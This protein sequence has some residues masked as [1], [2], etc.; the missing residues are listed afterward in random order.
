MATSNGPNQGQLISAAT[1]DS[2][3]VAFRKLL[4]AFD[5]RVLLTVKSRTNVVPGS[6]A[7]G[8]RYLV[9][10]GASG[11]WG[12]QVNSVAAW[13]TDDPATPGGYWEFH[14]PGEGWFAWS[15]AD[16][17]FYVFT[18]GAWAAF[19]GGGGG[20]STLAGD[21]DVVIASPAN[22]D[23]LTFETSSGKWK[24]KPAS[25]GGGGSSTLAG[26]SDVVIASPANNDLLTFETSSGKWKNKPASGGGGGGGGVPAG[27]NIWIALPRS[28]SSR[29]GL[30]SYSEYG[31]LSGG[32]ILAFATSWKFTIVFSD[33][34]TLGG[35]VV[36]RTLLDSTTIID[37]TPVTFAG[38]ASFPYTAPGSGELISDAIALPLDGT[39]DYYI[40]T[41]LVSGTIITADTF[42][43]SVNWQRFG[44]WVGGNR[45]GLTAGGTVDRPVGE[46]E[47]YRIIAA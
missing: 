16:A 31:Y 10:T 1:G 44:G 15:A 27:T 46:S 37:V 21:S 19:V 7:N 20:S 17:G 25:G 2:Y 24:N 47:I 23:L 29:D 36:Y 42:P 45:T 28:A 38:G 22:N 39:H 43:G 12:G 34:P 41:Y 35:A 32:A 11:A 6:P 13:T 40:A 8:D 30:G 33:T 14:V 9:T 26:D 18:A 5:V 4:R 3:D